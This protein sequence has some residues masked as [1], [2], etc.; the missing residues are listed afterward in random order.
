LQNIPNTCA[1]HGDLYVY[2]VLWN[3]D[4]SGVGVI[5]FSDYMVGD[6]ARNF[7]VFY[8]FGSEYAEMAYEKY[9][10]AKDKF[11]LQ[12]AQIYYKVHGIYTLLSS[13]LGA[14]ISFDYAYN[15]FFK[16]KFNV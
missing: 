9:E 13:L 3:K 2:N 6:P 8:D 15:H 10:G 14:D 4:N 5:D 1:V 16:E 11:F 12:R 7:E